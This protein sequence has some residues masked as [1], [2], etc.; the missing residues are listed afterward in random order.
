[1]SPDV[2]TCRSGN[3]LIDS[4]PNELAN[5]LS[6][7]GQPECV[8]LG[9]VVYR[10]DCS[11]SHVYFP[12]SA[13]YSQVVALKD[14]KRI[15]TATVGNEGMVGVHSVLGLELSPMTAVCQVPGE[16]LRIAVSAFVKIVQ[17]GDI[18]DRM[19]KRYAAYYLRAVHQAVACSAAHSVE[20]RICRRLLMVHDRTGVDEFP[21]TQE[22]LAD[23]LGLRRPT[24]THVAQ[25]LRAA[26]VIEYQRGVVRILDR[27]GLQRMSCECYLAIRT[28]YDSIVRNGNGHAPAC[29]RS[30]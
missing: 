26:G 20:E 28:A 11:T 8:R 19:L 3:R 25:L 13:V 16:S 2:L 22:S 29:R 4:L 15:E 18:L 17:P 9:D 27:R 10:Q 24:V 5:R 1:M 7:L 6:C 30:S 12:V 14:G 21:L 23:A